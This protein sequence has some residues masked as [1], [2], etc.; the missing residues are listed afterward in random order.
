MKSLSEYSREELIDR[1]RELEKKLKDS[2]GE[3]EACVDKTRISSLFEYSEKGLRLRLYGVLLKKYAATINER[4]K[5]TIGEVKGLVNGDD[6]TVQSVVSGLK[7]EKY[8]FERDF[9]SAAKKAFGFVKKEIHYAKA[10]LDL[11]YF[12]SPLEV[13]TEKIA[14]D[15]DQAVF[16]CSLIFALGDESASVVIAELDDLTT[17]AFVAIELAGKA[18]FLDPTQEHAFEQFSGK[19]EEVLK[20]YSY[21]GAKV[22]RLLY[23]FNKHEYKSFIEEE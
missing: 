21:A 7:P 2:K 5:K 8:S 16:L 15:E 17:H 10:D 11:D 18:Y 9:P 6:L 22:K 19:T 23:K 12:L 1:I 20:K 3:A 4:E 13:M 14:D